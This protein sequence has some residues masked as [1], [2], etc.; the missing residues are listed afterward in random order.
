MV[1]RVETACGRLTKFEDMTR[2]LSYVVMGEAGYV[3]ME[4]KFNN[5]ARE[6]YKDPRA[7]AYAMLVVAELAFPGH[8]YF[9]TTKKF[10]T[11]CSS[12][13]DVLDHVYRA[14]SGTP[15]PDLEMMIIEATK[16][17]ESLKKRALNVGPHR[18][19]AIQ[20]TSTPRYVDPS[21]ISYDQ[22]YGGYETEYEDDGWEYEYEDPEYYV[23]DWE[24]EAQEEIVTPQNQVCVLRYRGRGGRG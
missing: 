13:P 6:D 21:Y 22:S 1:N 19:L 16:A 20:A 5:M 15:V 24:S 9:Q 11:A 4:A 8:G 17:E 18:G 2:V 3:I 10:Q 7:F 14:S 12:D 23:E